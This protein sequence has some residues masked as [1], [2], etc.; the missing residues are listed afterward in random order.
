MAQWFSIEVM[1]GAFSANL[2][3][4]SFRDSII[5]A[6]ISHCAQD[7]NWHRH[8]WGVVLE[9]C[10]DDEASWDEFRSS[11]AVSAALDAVPDPLGG[12]IVYR[13]RGGSAGSTLPRRPRPL[14]GSGSACL[15]I[16][17]LFEELLFCR[18][19]SSEHALPL[20][21]LTLRT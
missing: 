12:L 20:C 2:W 5:E 18:S 15:P 1:D 6:A 10:F 4:E 14:V 3:A 21:T 8:N 11:S 7:W 19:V 17:N 16:P 13:G 9:V